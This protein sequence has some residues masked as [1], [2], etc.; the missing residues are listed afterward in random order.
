MNKIIYNE[1]LI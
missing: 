1:P